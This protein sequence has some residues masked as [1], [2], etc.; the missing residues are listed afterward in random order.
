[1]K[2]LQEF[3]V[4]LQQPGL[5]IG[6]GMRVAECFDN[7][8][9]F[10]QFVAQDLREQ[11]MLDLVYP[12]TPFPLFDSPAISSK[13]PAAL[14]PRLTTGLPL[15]QRLRRCA[16]RYFIDGRKEQ[17]CQEVGTDTPNVSYTRA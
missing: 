15:S 14:R 5:V 3:P 10:F 11:V 16:C 12:L 6:E 8:L 9:R 7:R 17:S 1:M 2:V 13:R 4:G